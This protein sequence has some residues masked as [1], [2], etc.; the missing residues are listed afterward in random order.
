[1]I[2]TVARLPCKF[3]VVFGLSVLR[4]R[5]VAPGDHQLLVKLLGDAMDVLEPLAADDP[6]LDVGA[7]D[8]SAVRFTQPLCRIQQ[9][10]LLQQGD[11]DVLVTDAHTRVDAGDP[12]TER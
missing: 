11:T 9:N 3:P 5:L 12:A 1:M 4:D 7:R 2:A 10:R 8:D 6:R